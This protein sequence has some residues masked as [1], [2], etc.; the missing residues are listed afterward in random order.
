MTA[1]GDREFAQRVLRG[2][3]R[4]CADPGLV[5]RLAAEASRRPA[6]A[7]DYAARM[8]AALE[9]LVARGLAPAELASSFPHVPPDFVVEPGA[10]DLPPSALTA[11]ALVAWLPRADE[12]AALCVAFLDAAHWWGGALRPGP[13]PPPPRAVPVSPMGPAAGAAWWA[14]IFDAWS[15]DLFLGD[16]GDVVGRDAAGLAW[17]LPCL[18][19]EDGPA[20][21]GREEAAKAWMAVLNFVVNPA[22]RWRALAR[23]GAWASRRSRHNLPTRR[24]SEIPDPFGPLVELVALGVVPLRA[25]DAGRLRLGLPVPVEAA[26]A[27]YGGGARAC[28]LAGP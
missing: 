9:V 13:A 2:A 12:A 8:G 19:V 24:W 25:S 14:G 11:A 1:E 4:P 20:W 22:L 7:G 28:M 16:V 3:L 21:V 18:D 17:E 5:A 6:P 23:G 27:L 26:A 15:L 10:Y